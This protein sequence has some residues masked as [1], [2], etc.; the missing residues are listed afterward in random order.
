MLAR[1]LRHYVRLHSETRRVPGGESGDRAN[2]WPPPKRPSARTTRT[3]LEPHPPL[4]VSISEHFE[5]LRSKPEHFEGC[6]KRLR[7]D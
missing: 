6:F 2:P 5:A 4:R 3:E 1:S 7:G